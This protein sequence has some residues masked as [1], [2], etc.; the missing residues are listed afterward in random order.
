LSPVDA[1]VATKRKHD[2]VVIGGANTDYLIR[3]GR[4]PRPGETVDGEEFLTAGGGKGANQGVAAARLGARVAFIA[5]VGNDERGEQLQK[6]LR[7]E[8]IDIDH[9]YRHPRSPTGVALVMVDKSGEKQ[10]LAAAGANHKLSP[11]HIARVASVI[12]QARV[13]LMQFEVPM[14]TVLKAA[15]IAQAAGVRIVL[16]PA[17]AAKAPDA[18]LSLVDVIRP[19]AIEAKALTGIEVND[20]KSARRA[21]TE[22]FARGVRAVAIQ[23]GH[24]G[25]LIIWPGGHRLMPRLKVKTVDATGAG[26][27]FAAGLA[28]ALAEGRS[29]ADAGAFANAAA[30]QATTRFGAMPAMPRRHQVL[31]LMKR[32]GTSNPR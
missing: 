3:G 28:V 7:S 17:P 22:L 26:D 4:L 23:A 5:C 29:Y 16:D 27:A 11:S 12:E 1:A 19:N 10:I 20:L 14:P 31:A 25:D 2:V 21:A 30:A 24:Q 18:L 32:A 9:L 15:K 8:Q 13:L 6:V